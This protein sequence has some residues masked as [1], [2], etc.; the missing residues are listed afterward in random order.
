MG[1]YSS[2]SLA[3]WYFIWQENDLSLCDFIWIWFAIRFEK[4]PTCN[5]MFHNIN[6]VYVA[7]TKLQ[8]QKVKLELGL[9]IWFVKKM[10]NKMIHDLISICV[11]NFFILEVIFYTCVNI[12][13]LDQPALL[14]G[15]VAGRQR[16]ITAVDRLIDDAFGFLT[17][18]RDDIA[19]TESAFHS[20]GFDSFMC[21]V[22]VARVMVTKY[23]CISILSQCL[24]V[25]LHNGP[26]QS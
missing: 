8:L 13:F 23:K 15:D 12:W 4:F 18:G 19:I 2:R 25:G 16:G 17:I 22:L 14:G 1:R 20:A 6:T 26:R 3:I 10:T 5:E 9:F 21:N 24:Q 11:Y 7:R